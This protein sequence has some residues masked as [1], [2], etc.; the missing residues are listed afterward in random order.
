MIYRQPNP[1]SAL[2]VRVLSK[3]HECPLLA[4]PTRATRSSRLIPRSE[5][6]P[7]LWV[8]SSADLEPQASFGHNPRALLETRYARHNPSVLGGDAALSNRLV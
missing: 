1:A 2:L 6:D 4:A 5:V 3:A 7:R 8:F